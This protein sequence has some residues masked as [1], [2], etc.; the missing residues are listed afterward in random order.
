MNRPRHIG[1]K[2]LG[3][4]GKHRAKGLCNLHYSRLIR[5]GTTAA[6]TPGIPSVT[7][8]RKAR[9]PRV[10]D[11]IKVTETIVGTITLEEWRRRQ[12]TPTPAVHI[13]RFGSTGG[14]V[15]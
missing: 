13:V 12:R 8:M 2:V 7:D 5:T 1:C 10:E 14:D 3:C 11:A 4:D 15:A 6:P 9:R